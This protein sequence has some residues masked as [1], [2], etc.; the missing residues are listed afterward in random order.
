MYIYN[1]KLGNIYLLSDGIY[2]TGL[3][4][5][6]YN[7]KIKGFSYVISNRNDS[8]FFGTCNGGSS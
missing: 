2:L 8:S 3:S 5:N 1:S 6:K 7:Y 4:F